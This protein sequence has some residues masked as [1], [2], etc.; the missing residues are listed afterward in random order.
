MRKWMR[1]NA[2]P[3]FTCSSGHAARRLWEASSLL[4]TC[5]IAVTSEGQQWAEYVPGRPLMALDVLR[6]AC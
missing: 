6:L 5:Q 1:W 3:G 4:F 2:A